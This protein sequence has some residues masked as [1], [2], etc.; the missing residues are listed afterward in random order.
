MLERKGEQLNR[1]RG[2]VKGLQ[3]KERDRQNIISSPTKS[4]A[5]RKHYK[6]MKVL[7]DYRNINTDQPNE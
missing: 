6:S 4:P 2:H 1:L 5:A 7:Q 3:E